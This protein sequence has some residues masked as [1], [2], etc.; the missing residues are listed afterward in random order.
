M[1]DCSHVVIVVLLSDL[2]FGPEHFECWVGFQ[3][4]SMRD[5]AEYKLGSGFANSV[6]IV[7][8]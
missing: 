7:L 5:V 2:L 3:D 6:D 1:L 4:I 8:R